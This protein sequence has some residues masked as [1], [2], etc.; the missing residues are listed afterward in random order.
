MD[1]IEKLWKVACRN[2]NKSNNLYVITSEEYHY[3]YG[4][5]PLCDM[6][7]DDMFTI[8]DWIKTNYTER[9]IKKNFGST[10]LHSQLNTY[11]K[12]QSYV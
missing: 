3:T 8:I 10:D 6:C 2:K 4:F 1:I 7:I 11:L 12:E 5:N 9:T